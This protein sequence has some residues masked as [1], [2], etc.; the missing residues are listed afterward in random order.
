MTHIF[1]SLTQY[2]LLIVIINTFM[3]SCYINL[4]MICPFLSHVCLQLFLVPLRKK[5]AK[6]RNY[7]YVIAWQKCIEFEKKFVWNHPR[8]HIELNCFTLLQVHKKE[9]SRTSGCRTLERTDKLSDNWCPLTSCDEWLCAVWPR[10]KA[11][12]NIWLCHTRKVI[13][14]FFTL[15][16]NH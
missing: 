3:Q 12:D 6:L 13:Y 4:T 14:L 9:P 11:G 7:Y 2:R 16:I 1:P 8:V 5:F 15:H 10:H